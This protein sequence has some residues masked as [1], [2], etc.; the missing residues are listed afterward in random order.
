MCPI[1]HTKYMCFYQILIFCLL[2]TRLT[3]IFLFFLQTKWILGLYVLPRKRCGQQKHYRL[4]QTATANVFNCAHP[5]HSHVRKFPIERRRRDQQWW[6]HRCWFNGRYR[7]P[8]TAQQKGHPSA[9]RRWESL[10]TI[11]R[12][13]STDRRSATHTG[14][15]SSQISQVVH[16]RRCCRCRCRS[17]RCTVRCLVQQ[18]AGSHPVY[19]HQETSSYLWQGIRILDCVDTSATHRENR[20]GLVGGSM[21]YL[22]WRLCDFRGQT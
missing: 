13:R 11:P 4:I 14:H 3:N 15:R 17:T 7:C 18:F 2:I 6:G 16:S 8:N 10:S 22:S 12:T 5:T 19:H 20:A 21:W 9:G 1:A